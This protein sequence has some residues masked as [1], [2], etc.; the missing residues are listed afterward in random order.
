MSSRICEVQCGIRTNRNKY[1]YL[2]WNPSQ[3]FSYAVN[4]M[5]IHPLWMFLMIDHISFPFCY[6]TPHVVIFNCTKNQSIFTFWPLQIGRATEAPRVVN[7][8]TTTWEMPTQISLAELFMQG[9]TDWSSLQA[10]EQRNPLPPSSCCSFLSN[11][12]TKNIFRTGY[13]AP[14][15]DNSSL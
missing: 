8:V 11:H 5:K 1:R 6:V 13:V 14:L 15:R 3:R 2:I 10:A 4:T 12:S 7:Q 9:F